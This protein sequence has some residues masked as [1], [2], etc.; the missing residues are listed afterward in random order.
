M[1]FSDI[2]I[3]VLFH[4]D[5]VISDHADYIGCF[6]IT[7]E[8]PTL[9]VDSSA[10]GLDKMTVRTCIEKCRTM[11]FAYAGLSKHRYSNSLELPCPYLHLERS[12]LDEIG[13]IYARLV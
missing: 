13:R 1:L 9:A 11:G 5:D 3:T 8:T 4:L 2:I 12:D 10:G 6:Q 7:T